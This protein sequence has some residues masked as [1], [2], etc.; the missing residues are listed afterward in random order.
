MA[1]AGVAIAS[2]KAVAATIAVAAVRQPIVANSPAVGQGAAAE[3]EQPVKAARAPTLDT[4]HQQ[5]VPLP[6]MQR[7]PMRAHRA[8]PQAVADTPVAVA[9]VMPPAAADM[10]ANTSN[11]EPL[12]Q[13]AGC[14]TGGGANQL[15]RFAFD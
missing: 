7:L 14:A 11:L 2:V 1:T 13:A 6:R 3:A 5:A 12:N 9:A 8:L 4:P 10:A 15:R